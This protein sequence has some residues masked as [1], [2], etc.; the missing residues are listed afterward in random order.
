MLSLRRYSIRILVMKLSECERLQLINQ[1]KIISKLDP[2]AKDDCKDKIEILERGYEA[3]YDDLIVR[4]RRPLPEN[5]GTEVIKTLAIYRL[6]QDSFNECSD[7]DGLTED[8]VLCPPFQSSE[9][10]EFAHFLIAR[11]VSLRCLK[12]AAESPGGKLNRSIFERARSLSQ[13]TRLS[14]TEIRYVL[15]L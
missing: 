14:A 6:L 12:I 8:M 2:I 11:D 7:K 15:G 4:L 5:L 10:M 13:K 3:L 1:L 9:A